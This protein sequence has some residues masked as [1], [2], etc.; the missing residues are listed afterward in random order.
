ME[1]RLE[2][3]PEEIAKVLEVLKSSAPRGAMIE[4]IM[5]ETSYPS[6]IIYSAIDALKGQGINV[7]GRNPFEYDPDAVEADTDAHGN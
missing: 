2:A 4:Q 3:N 7:Q 1:T 6:Y 5:E